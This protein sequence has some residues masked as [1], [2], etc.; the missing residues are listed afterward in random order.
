MQRDDAEVV[1]KSVLSQS[2]MDEAFRCKPVE[3][4]HGELSP[5]AGL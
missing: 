5:S 1:T 2:T 4:C 3:G